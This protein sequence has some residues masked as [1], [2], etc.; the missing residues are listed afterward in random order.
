LG[1]NRRAGPHDLK[2]R[3]IG[4]ANRGEKPKSVTKGKTSTER[5]KLWHSRGMVW[6]MTADELINHFRWSKGYRTTWVT[7]RAALPPGV[8]LAPGTGR[9]NPF[10]GKELKG[11]PGSIWVT[12]RSQ[13]HSS[14][15]LSVDRCGNEDERTR[16]VYKVLKRRVLE[17]KTASMGA[18]AV[19]NEKTISDFPKRLPINQENTGDSRERTANRIIETLFS[20]GGESSKKDT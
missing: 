20:K 8:M 17:N 7:S 13:K 19:F 4:E 16:L 18:L 1:D 9:V 15:K 2:E 6:I 11:R 10:S 14:W 12:V 3:A 5:K